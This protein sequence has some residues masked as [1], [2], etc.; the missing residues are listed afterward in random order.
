M[1]KGEL[2][3]LVCGPEYA[4]G[5]NG[6][7]DKIPPDSTLVFQVELLSWE[8]KYTDFVKNKGIWVGCRCFLLFQKFRLPGI[9]FYCFGRLID[10]LVKLYCVYRSIHW[11]IDWLAKLYCVYRSIHWLIDWLIL[12]KVGLAF[13]FFLRF[14]FF[15]LFRELWSILGWGYFAGEEQ[16]NLPKSVDSRNGIFFSERRSEMPRWVEF[17]HNARFVF[18]PHLLA[19]HTLMNFFWFNQWNWLENWAPRHSMNEKWTSPLARRR[20]RVWLPGSTRPCWRWSRAK[21][22][23]SH[24]TPI[25]LS[26][27]LESRSGELSRT[28]KWNMKWH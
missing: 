3:E 27:R 23:S 1:K 7:G 13:L 22:H 19:L 8:V 28:R 6:S 18:S 11:L 26:G 20:K 5:K 2:A 14:H 4:Y 16:E 9:S 25:R 24:S 17:F 12:S 21:P 15:S 10:W